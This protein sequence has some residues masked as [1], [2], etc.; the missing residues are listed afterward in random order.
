ME[1]LLKPAPPWREGKKKGRGR[2]WEGGD[3]RGNGWEG[4]KK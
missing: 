4:E 3:R 1:R 2:E